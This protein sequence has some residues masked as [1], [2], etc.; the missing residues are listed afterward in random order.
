MK[1]LTITFKKSFTSLFFFLLMSILL[2]NGCLGSKSVAPRFYLLEFPS[3]VN[4]EDA[5]DLE[6][7]SLEIMDVEIHPAFASYEIAVR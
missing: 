5:S 2:F 1:N 6:T 7:V 4:L 3:E